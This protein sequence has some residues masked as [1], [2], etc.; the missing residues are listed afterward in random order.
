MNRKLGIGRLEEGELVPLIHRQSA[1]EAF[2]GSG[3]LD[4]SREK[5]V[6][7]DSNYQKM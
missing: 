6:R 2:K 3:L 4:F 1:G 5:N 7:L